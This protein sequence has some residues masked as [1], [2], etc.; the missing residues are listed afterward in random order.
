MFRFPYALFSS[1]LMLPSWDLIAQEA[2]QEVMA[3]VSQ[4]RGQVTASGKQ[5]GDLKAG[6]QLSSG[7][8]IQTGNDGAV[9]IRPAPYIKVALLPSSQA[10]FNGSQIGTDGAVASFELLEGTLFCRD[11]SAEATVGSSPKVTPSNGLTG[12]EP[13]MVLP[14]SSG[15]EPTMV[16]PSSSA[17]KV[18]T[19]NGLI[20]GKNGHFLVEQQGNRTMVANVLGDVTV[21]IGEGGGTV[22]LG[23]GEVII[24]QPNQQGR[25]EVQMIDLTN[26]TMVTIAED[27]SR[28]PVERAGA[29]LM[30]QAANR[31]GVAIALT[32]IESG[33]G[34]GGGGSGSGT[35]QEAVQDL[36]EQ[37]NQVVPDFANDLTSQPTTPTSPQQVLNT[38][39]VSPETNVTK[40]TAS[41][42]APQ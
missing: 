35:Q 4:V 27:G 29:L 23:A 2:A 24:L 10:R 11:Q 33:S 20:T 12:K 31:M 17:I 14:G 26:G 32:L 34:G 36:V 3:T 40:P 1:L 28:G 13:S 25:L 41:P 16:L 21:R 5:S 30:A 7:T 22:E 42:D 39:F 18:T 37:I 38:D 8:V 19:S 15:K 9:L 6:S